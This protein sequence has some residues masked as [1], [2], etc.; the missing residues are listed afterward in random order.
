MRMQ[1]FARW[2]ALALVASLLTGCELAA[3]QVLAQFDLTVEPSEVE[4]DAGGAGSVTVGI[5]PLVAVTFSRFTIVLDD[6]APDEDGIT[7][8]TLVVF[9]AGEHPW[10]IAVGDGVPPGTYQL[11]AE[12]V[13]QGT[14]LLPVERR[15]TFEVV[16]R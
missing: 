10:E 8:K 11:T 4:I 3:G 15:A 14:N 7:A 9:G 12:A 2:S 1:A 13:S 16:V 5:E 6:V